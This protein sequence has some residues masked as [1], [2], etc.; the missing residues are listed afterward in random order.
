MKCIIIGCGKVGITL[1]EQLCQENHD[2]VIMDASAKRMQDIPENIDAMRIVG[3]GAS[4]QAQMEAGVNEADILIAVTGSD[5]LNLLCCLIAKKAGKCSTIARVRNPVYSKEINF[6]KERLGVSMTINPELTAATE[7]AR[8]LRFPSAIKIDTFAKGRVEL[9]KFKIRP[10]FK[11]DQLA[12]SALQNTLKS[13]ILV[14]AVEREDNVYIPNGDFILKDGDLVSIIASPQN[15]ANFFQTIGLKTNQVRNCMIVGGGTIAFYLAKELLSMKIPVRIVEKDPARCE[16]LS[17]ELPHATIICGDGTDRKL[18]LEEGLCTAE[19]FVSLTN[20][21]EENLM[22]ALFAKDQSSAKLVTKVNRL[23]FDEI[24][25]RL[26][27]GS[28][29]YPKYL[30]ADYILQYVRA[31]QNTIGSN[32]ETLYQILDDRAEALE[33]AIHEESPV[34]DNPLMELNLKDNLLIGCIHRR[35]RVFI[36]RGHDSIQ[37]GDTVII[38]TTQVGLQ[39]IRDILK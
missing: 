6:I 15:A 30:T 36:P 27:I 28:V 13:N 5:E 35:E 18:L 31:M 33:F 17:Q 7:I 21:D 29:V 23:A 3:N 14:A 25:E 10:Q 8:L 9:L 38:V 39:D 2:V 32:V 34:T 19:G 37:V 4:I 26:D 22:L 11:L 1:A 12:V 20:M 16:L 24:I